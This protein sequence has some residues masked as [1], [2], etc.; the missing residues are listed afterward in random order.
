MF[1]YFNVLGRAIPSYGVMV[2]VGILI[3][4]VVLLI[5]CKKLDKSF[6][7]VIYIYAFSLIGIFLGARLLFTL[8]EI[9]QYGITF[10][11][12]FCGGFVFWGGFIGGWLASIAAAR[13][14]EKDI[15][16]YYPILVPAAILF[17]GF[18]RIGCFL[19]GCCYGQESE[20]YGLSYSCSQIAPNGIPLIP[21]QLIEAVFDFTLAFLLF[22]KK[23]AMN[24]YA[25]MYSMF[26]FIAE[27]FRGDAARGF[28]GVLSVSQCISLVV[29]VVVVVRGVIVREGCS[30]LINDPLK[31]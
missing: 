20:I 24:R 15:S 31:T 13:Y 8:V 9:P 27:F 21:I 7:D 10:E 3:S 14:F 19:T 26:R 22:G 28:I 12:V 29:L 11:T 17:A 4:I 18:G 5:G 6:D 16:D 25:W 1:P 2:A 23:H 30:E